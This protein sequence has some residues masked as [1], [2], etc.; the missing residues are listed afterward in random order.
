MDD[1][2]MLLQQAL[3]M[4]VAA[5]GGGGVGGAPATEVRVW[6][7]SYSQAKRVLGGFGGFRRFIPHSGQVEASR[8]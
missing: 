6:P 1:D 7:W 8:L 2:D 3:A 4:S 5:E